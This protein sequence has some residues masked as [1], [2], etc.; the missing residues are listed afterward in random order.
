M[1]HVVSHARQIFLFFFFRPTVFN[2]IKKVFGSLFI[3]C[4]KCKSLNR[5][6]WCLFGK[7]MWISI[8]NESR[9]CLPCFGQSKHALTTTTSGSSSF[10]C[11]LIAHVLP[12]SSKCQWNLILKGPKNESVGFH[13]NS[14]NVWFNRMMSVRWKFGSTVVE[15]SLTHYLRFL[16]R[17]HIRPIDWW[18]GRRISHEFIH[19]QIHIGIS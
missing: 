9:F 19:S 1:F 2:S 14:R 7:K 4:W 6:V 16:N 8:L 3:M 15:L 11:T 17:W 5:S 12:V 13:F 10:T 18:Y